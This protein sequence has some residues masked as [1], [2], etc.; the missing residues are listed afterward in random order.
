MSTI[1]LPPIAIETTHAI[2]LADSIKKITR[3]LKNSNIAYFKYA[4]IYNS[5]ERIIFSNQPDMIEY[6]YAPENLVRC[7]FYNQKQNEN[8]TSFWQSW[9]V[10]RLFNTE[11]QIRFCKELYLFFKF[12]EGF[13]YIQK[14]S[15]F[16]EIFDFSGIDKEIY[17]LDKKTL[18]KFIYYFK[19]QAKKLIDKAEQEKI[20]LPL[21][22]DY[23]STSPETSQIISALSVKRFYLNGK[24]SGIYL[25][26]REVECIQL[27]IQGHSSAEIAAALGTRNRTIQHHFENIKTK[28]N[29]SKLTDIIRIA[30]EQNLIN[31]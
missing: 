17:T 6:F 31:I 3:P 20:Y 8:I 22:E 2:K 23:I 11:E 15:D 7:W 28:L 19:E 26:A 12:K 16:F 5:G 14:H 24:Y 13:T 29:C 21:Q 18:Y 4:K 30:I 27:T 25:T 1:L 9:Q 10:Q